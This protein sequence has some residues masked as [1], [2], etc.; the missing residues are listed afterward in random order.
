M[1]KV[2]VPKTFCMDVPINRSVHQSYPRVMRNK[3]EGSLVVKTGVGSVDRRPSRTPR[4]WCGVPIF[5]IIGRFKVLKQ[6]VLLLLFLLTSS[7]L[8]QC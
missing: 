8:I 4:L 1:T 5:S 3:T 7:F 2:Q 6:N